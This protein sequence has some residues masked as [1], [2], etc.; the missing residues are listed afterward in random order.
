MLPEVRGQIQRRFQGMTGVRA[1]KRQER[2]VCLSGA[3]P[4]TCMA[5]FYNVQNP[6]RIYSNMFNST[7]IGIEGCVH[8]HR[9]ALAANR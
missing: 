5:S 7:C 3:L 2:I 1:H 9:I 8:P 6:A 4:K